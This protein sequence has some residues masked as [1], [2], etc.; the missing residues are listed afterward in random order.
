MCSAAGYARGMRLS[1]QGLKAV[2]TVMVGQES[3][4][5][6]PPDAPPLSTGWC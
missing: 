1:S 2:D 6:L 5:L 3:L 4:T